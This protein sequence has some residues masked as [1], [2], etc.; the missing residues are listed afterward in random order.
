MAIKTPYPIPP[1]TDH[2]EYA[3]LA[4]MRRAV[5]DAVLDR[6]RQ[7]DLLSIEREL[8]FPTSGN[9]HGPRADMMRER[10]ATL[11]RAAPPEKA[12]V[13]SPDGLPANI[14]RA[15]AIIGGETVDAPP[16]R[17]ALRTR[18]RIEIS[19]LEPALREIDILMEEARAEQSHAIALRLVA[20]NNAIIR[21]IYEA[22]AALSAAMQAERA[23]CAQILIAGYELRADITHRPGLDGAS[24]LGTLSDWDSQ[25]SM[26]RRRFELLGVL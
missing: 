7:I 25:I 12:D 15:I 5:G 1:L 11:R 21:T 4:T 3:R 23:L 14:A 20:Q 22:A 6:Q 26:F 2:P 17:D 9:A 8:A 19:V 16:D 10:A 24:R 13:G 18:L